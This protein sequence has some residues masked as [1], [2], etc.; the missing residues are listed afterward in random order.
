MPSSSSQGSGLELP[1][2]WGT[3]HPGLD[4]SR[5][6]GRQANPYP[7]HHPFLP[8]LGN[9][10]SILWNPAQS[11]VP[12]AALLS[13]LQQHSHLKLSS[14]HAVSKDLCLFPCQRGSFVVTIY[15]FLKFCAGSL[16]STLS[17]AL[18]LSI[19]RAPASPAAAAV[20]SPEW[21]PTCCRLH[22]LY[23]GATARIF[24]PQALSRRWG[25]VSFLGKF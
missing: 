1:L 21:P 19:P 15:S 13:S 10:S 23:H 25:S 8:S 18:T 12:V 5:R 2:G 11:P 16:L 7:E 22:L 14:S 3:P 6:G 24:W 4:A 20:F 17:T 9:P